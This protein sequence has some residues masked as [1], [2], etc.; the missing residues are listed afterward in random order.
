M[1]RLRHGRG[2]TATETAAGA[3]FLFQTEFASGFST[4]SGNGQQDGRQKILAALRVSGG[5]ASDSLAYPRCGSKSMQHSVSKFIQTFFFSSRISR[6]RDVTHQFPSTTLRMTLSEIGIPFE[7]Q[8][9]GELMRILPFP[10]PEDSSADTVA[11]VIVY[12]QQKGVLRTAVPPRTRE[13]FLNGTHQCHFFRNKEDLLALAAAYFREGLAVNDLCVWLVHDPISP[14]L[15][16]DK[17]RSWVPN[18]DARLS[19]GD[20]SVV[21]WR[22]WYIT[23]LEGFKNRQQMVETFRQM[24]SD[25]RK[26]GYRCL[27]AAGVCTWRENPVARREFLLF[28]KEVNSIF[29]S[30][31]LIALCSYPADDIEGERKEVLE[32]HP[33][34]AVTSSDAEFSITET[35]DAGA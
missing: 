28:E 1:I 6:V 3:G 34:L 29:A 17:L 25:V 20:I 4:G 30:T 5:D 16:I 18:F 2:K 35:A 27:R 32:A 26:K 9:A 23:P 31:G 10:L 12:L 11:E 15:A 19:R 8:S 33:Q 22:D 13:R 7:K 14:E 24:G 21:S